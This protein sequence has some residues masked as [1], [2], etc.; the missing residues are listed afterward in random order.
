MGIKPI[1]PKPGPVKPVTPID[2]KDV[3]D[4][5][6][7][8]LATLLKENAND[9]KSFELVKAV[10]TDAGGICLRIRSR[11]GFGALVLEDL[12]VNKNNKPTSWAAACSPAQKPRDVTHIKY[13][14]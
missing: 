2:P 11:N 12:A 4:A 7:L 14:L 8:N 3:Q 1:D 5:R 6:A 13:L 10:V 9:P